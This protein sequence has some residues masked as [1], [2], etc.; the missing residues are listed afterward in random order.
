MRQ[1]AAYVARLEPH[2]GWRIRTVV[3]EVDTDVDDGD[4]ARMRSSRLEDETALARRERHCAARAHCVSVHHSRQAVDARRDVDRDHWAGPLRQLVHEPR[5]V[6]LERATKAGAVH[7]IDRHVGVRQR[8]RDGAPIDTGRELDDLGAHSPTLE[9]ARGDHTVTAVVALAADDDGAAPV[10]TPR[11]AA[12]LPRHR[13]PG[14]F[15]ENGLRRSRIDRAPVGATHRLRR[16]DGL[17]W[18]T[19]PVRARSRPAVRRRRSRRPS[20]WTP[21]G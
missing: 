20:R 16:E 9:R 11:D 8:A 14:A 18:L 2:D 21:Y 1:R 12:H 3:A 6:A 13:P 15:H 10:T 4:T 7:R 5:G 19:L 17:H